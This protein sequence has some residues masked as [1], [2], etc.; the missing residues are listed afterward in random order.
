VGLLIGVNNMFVLVCSGFRVYPGRLGTSQ[1]RGPE[2][3][4]K[5]F[6]E[7]GSSQPGHFFSGFLSRN[8]FFTLARFRTF[9]VA[10]FIRACTSI[11][12]VL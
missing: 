3:I 10:P 1:P 11:S 6:F 4:H 7:S 8:S 12:V 2:R 9:L 5:Y